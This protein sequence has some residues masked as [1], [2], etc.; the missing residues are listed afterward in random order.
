MTTQVILQT[1]PQNK[2]PSWYQNLTA[3]IQGN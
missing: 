3:K 2:T 1:N